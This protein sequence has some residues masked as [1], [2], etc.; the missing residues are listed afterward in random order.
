M[1][2]SKGGYHHMH[3]EKIL[4]PCWWRWW[5]PPPLPWPPPNRKPKTES[6]LPKH[7]SNQLKRGLVL[8]VAK[9][10]L[11][12]GSGD[13]FNDESLLAGFGR[14]LIRVWFRCIQTGSILLIKQGQPTKAAS[15]QLIQIHLEFKLLSELIRSLWTQQKSLNSTKSSYKMDVWTN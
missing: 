6:R 5:P 9:K 15:A 11:K 7:R 12:I 13:L 8:V 10:P 14:K 4:K 1:Y 3:K 2:T